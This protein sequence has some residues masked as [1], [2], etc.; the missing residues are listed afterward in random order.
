MNQAPTSPRL[1]DEG[2]AFTVLVDSAPYQ[3]V[4][5]EDALQHLSSKKS[6]DAPA[7]D[8]ME[9]FNAYEASI[10]GVGRRLVAAGVKGSP[11]HI[12]A[13]TFTRPPHTA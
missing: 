1:T 3:C 2:V 7:I 8:A 5:S 11:V 13:N 4:I 12:T 10:R 9:V 6:S